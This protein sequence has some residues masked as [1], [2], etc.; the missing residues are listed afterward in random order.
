MT[1]SDLIK[2]IRATYE[3]HGWE[4]KSALLRPETRAVVEN[5]P[6]NILSGATIQDSSFDALWFSRPSDSGAEAWELRLVAET[7]YALFEKVGTNDP[8]DKRASVLQSMEERMGQHV[9]GS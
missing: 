7:P 1:K 8:K 4:L 9:T 2:E 3:K 5:G 6:E